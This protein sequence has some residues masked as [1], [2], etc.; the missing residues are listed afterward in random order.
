[1]EKL[2]T[3]AFAVPRDPSGQRAAAI[4]AAVLSERVAERARLRPIEPGR[5]LSG[6][7]RTREEETLSRARTALADGRRVYDALN[8]DEAIA[9]LGQAVSLYQ[10]TGPLLG[11]L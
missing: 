9:R 4:V 2:A 7:P 6:D 3:A 10:Q 11:D 8:L 5:A 1:M